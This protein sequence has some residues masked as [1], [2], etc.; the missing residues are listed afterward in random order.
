MVQQADQDRVSHSDYSEGGQT[1]SV[2]NSHVSD[3]LQA[4][5]CLTSMWA[6]CHQYGLLN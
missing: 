5:K 2:I 6:V 3:C 1:L 4:I